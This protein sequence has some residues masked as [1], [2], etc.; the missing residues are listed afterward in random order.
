MARRISKTTGKAKVVLLAVVGFV[1]L[2]A[3]TVGVTWFLS[4]LVSPFPRKGEGYAKIVISPEK[5]L[6]LQFEGERMRT[7][8]T[9]EG[10]EQAEWTD[11]THEEEEYRSVSPTLPLPLESG[12]PNGWEKAGVFFEHHWGNYYGIRWQLSKSDSAGA[13]WTYEVSGG[14]EPKKSL[15][16][17]PEVEVPDLSNP[18]LE[19]SVGA[20]YDSEDDDSE[21]SP[22]V[23][24]A[25]ILKSG[26]Y[27][28][29]AEI[30]KDGVP[31]KAQVRVLDS[32]GT[33]IETTELPLSELGFT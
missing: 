11:F 6:W 5:T 33:L 10:L 15:E 4:T 25:V 12:A 32:E 2:C 28:E 26:D 7:A 9:P 1:V 8:P 31:V 14:I 23:G 21:P 30:L 13:E 19:V 16:A 20:Q 18:T 3:W 24:V 29:C 22:A 27:C 17:C